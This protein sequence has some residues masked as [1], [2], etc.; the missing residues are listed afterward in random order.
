VLNSGPRCTR[1]MRVT[2]CDSGCVVCGVWCVVGGGW[3]VVGGGWWVVGGGWW[4]VGVCGP[5]SGLLD[6]KDTHRPG[7]LRYG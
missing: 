4:V 5:H 1:C 3:W 7:V 2:R 6:I